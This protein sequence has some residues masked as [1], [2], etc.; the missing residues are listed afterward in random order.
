MKTFFLLASLIWT[1]VLGDIWLSRGMK[2]FGAVTF[3]W[4]EIPTLIGFL[5]TSP[6]IWLGVGCLVLSLGIYLTAISRLDLSYVLPIHAFSYVLN[7]ILAGWILGEQI[8]LLRWV[9]TCLITLGVLL[10]GLGESQTSRLDKPQPLI[11]KTRHFPLF[12]AP[13][14]LAVSKSWLAIFVIAIA[15]AS[16]DVL[17]ALGMKQAGRVERSSWKDAIALV[18]RVVINPAI[19]GGILCQTVAFTGFILVLSWADISFVRPG[20]ALTYIFSLIGAKFLLKETITREKLMGI[21]LVGFGIA[22]HH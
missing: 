2:D 5:L 12:I 19:L 7:A 20:T 6:W 11:N 10:V 9:S 15:D 13:L 16:G 21:I 17:L 4:R 1:Q 8:P 22:I 18:R 3:H 14:G